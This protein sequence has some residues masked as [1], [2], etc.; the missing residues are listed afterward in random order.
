MRDCLCG[1]FCLLANLL[2]MTEKSFVF[3]NVE[4]KKL[5]LWNF[6][7]WSQHEEMEKFSF[8]LSLFLPQKRL[9]VLWKIFHPNIALSHKYTGRD[10][11]IFQIPF[12]QNPFNMIKLK[13]IKRQFCHFIEKIYKCPLDQKDDCQHFTKWPRNLT[14]PNVFSVNCTLP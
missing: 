4:G 3:N 10:R 5:S 2:L 8:S 7:G 9:A 12:F 11:P 13:L 6:F 14:Y 1:F